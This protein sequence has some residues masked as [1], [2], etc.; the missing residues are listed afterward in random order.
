MKTT[1]LPLCLLSC[2]ALASP[3]DGG[4]NAREF[5]H[6]LEPGGVA[7]ECLRL[8]AGKAR[9][10]EWSASA[11]VDFNIHYHRGNDVT[12]PVKANQQRDGKGR[13]TAAAAE[14]YCWMWTAK[15]ATRITGKLGAEE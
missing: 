4:T 13:F 15:G 1:F 12:Y 7:E 14:D 2:A 8:P 5:S 9:R 11:P 10:F 6:D 3:V